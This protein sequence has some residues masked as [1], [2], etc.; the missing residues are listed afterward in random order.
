[1]SAEKS[2]PRSDA[3]APLVRDVTSD[4]RGR[5][6]SLLAPHRPGDDL[7]PGLRFVGASVELGLRL[8]FE[9]TG[10]IVHVDVEPGEDALR[11][12]AR[13]ERLALSYRTGTGSGG[14]HVTPQQGKALCRQIAD[15]IAPN[16]ARVLERLAEDAAAVRERSVGATRVREVRVQSLLEPAEWHG[17]RYYTVSPYVGCLIGCRFCYAQSRV[18]MARR[19]EGLRE[20]PWGSYLDVRANAPEVLEAELAALS[21]APIKF[22]PVVSDPYHAIEARLEV[23]RRCLEALR[24]AE[25]PFPTMVL[26]RARLVER[27]AALLGAL[28][29]AY[30]GVSIPTIDDD[31]RRHFEPRGAPIAD[32]L[33]ALATLRAHGVRTFA[34]IQPML[35]GS[36]EAL[37]DALAS[38]V[39]SA[40]LDVLTS[41]EGAEADFAD[42]RYAIARDPSWQLERASE[43]LEALASRGVVV[44]R[45]EL[46]PEL[47]ASG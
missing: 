40:S 28:P 18:A 35:P 43:L 33:A 36:L 39:S 24:R 30:A 25:R 29:N 15:V 23:T 2:R 47:R 11:F 9:L 41:I 3:A 1:M 5:L 21:P 12:A 46:P 4:L 16:E 44:W 10:R 13:T 42:P 20:V 26:T 31:V 37:A 22:C 45:G 34:V 7:A 19:L 8:T 32:R 38:R 14:D 17:T 27:D 6:S